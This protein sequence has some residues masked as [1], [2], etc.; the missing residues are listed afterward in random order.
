MRLGNRDMCFTPASLRAVEADT[1]GWI[2]FE[3]GEYILDE[4]VRELR[5]RFR[6]S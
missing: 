2:Q 6:T 3:T 1:Q 4:K 5:F